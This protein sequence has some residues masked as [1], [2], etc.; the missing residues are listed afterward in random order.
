MLLKPHQSIIGF[1]GIRF[2]KKEKQAF[3]WNTDYYL[4]IYNFEQ[5]V[6]LDEL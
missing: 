3:I 6:V 1:N 5:A 2:N 4:S